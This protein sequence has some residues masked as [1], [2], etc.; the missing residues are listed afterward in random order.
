[1]NQYVE[2]MAAPAILLDQFFALIP[3]LMAQWCGSCCGMGDFMLGCRDMISST[4]GSCFGSMHQFAIHFNIPHSLLPSP[5]LYI[6]SRRSRKVDGT[7]LHGNNDIDTDGTEDIEPGAATSKQL[8][9]VRRI[10]MLI[11]NALYQS[12]VDI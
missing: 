10:L 1:M 6:S 4:Q 2:P 5:T 3:Y 7:N 11:P 8:R 9:Y 12:V